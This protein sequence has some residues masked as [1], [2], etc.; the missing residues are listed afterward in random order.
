M[1]HVVKPYFRQYV[2]MMTM[3]RIQIGSHMFQNHQCL[4]YL[5]TTVQ[6]LLMTSSSKQTILEFASMEH[7]KSIIPYFSNYFYLLLIEGSFKWNTYLV[8]VEITFRIQQY[9]VD[10]LD[11]DGNIFYIR[12]HNEPENVTFAISSEA[13]IIRCKTRSAAGWSEINEPRILKFCVWFV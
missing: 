11:E 10:I 5:I 13:D 3:S 7:I 6:V 8:Y 4:I 2:N 1:L 12:L 9:S